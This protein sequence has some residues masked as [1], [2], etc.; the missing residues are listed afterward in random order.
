MARARNIGPEDLH[1]IL[2]EIGLTQE[3]FGE[4]FGVHQTTVSR[5]LDTAVPHYVQTYLEIRYPE[6]L[7][8]YK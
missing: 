3:E 6:I 8:D 5:W 1:R 7:D 2:N 4:L